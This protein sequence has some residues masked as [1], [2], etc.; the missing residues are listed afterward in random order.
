MLQNS[1]HSPEGLH[2]ILHLGNMFILAA[3]SRL[4]TGEQRFLL[5]LSSRQQQNCFD[6]LSMAG[7]LK[8]ILP[9]ILKDNWRW[10]SQKIWETQTS[11]PSTVTCSF[12]CFIFG[13]RCFCI[14]GMRAGYPHKHFLIQSS[15]E[16]TDPA[17]HLKA[18]FPS[19][20][21]VGLMS[22]MVDKPV[23]HA[24]LWVIICV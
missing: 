13:M 16:A 4:V 14:L 1:F 24:R 3:I 11:D 20:W 19:K 7:I 22:G 17:S 6:F 10:I 23:P 12:S 18:T 9:N 2:F 5:N 15:S 21:L 8:N